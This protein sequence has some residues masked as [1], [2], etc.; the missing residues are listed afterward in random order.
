MPTFERTYSQA[1]VDKVLP[2]Q[3]ARAKEIEGNWHVQQELASRGATQND[4]GVYQMDSIPV[5]EQLGILFDFFIWDN[6]RLWKKK[7]DVEAAQSAAAADIHSTFED[8]GSA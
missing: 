1:F 6:Y 3:L 4:D 8:G 2:A 7:T 5:K